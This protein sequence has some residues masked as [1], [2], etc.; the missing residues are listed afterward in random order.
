MP[1][2]CGFIEAATY[3][4]A[5]S[6][7]SLGDTCQQSSLVLHLTQDITFFF[8]HNRRVRRLLVCLYDLP[9]R[10][11]YCNSHILLYYF[12][13]N[14]FGKGGFVLHAY[15]IPRA[16]GPIV[17]EMLGGHSRYEGCFSMEVPP[18]PFTPWL[19][20]KEKKERPLQYRSL[21]LFSIFRQY[22]CD[23]HSQTPWTP[24]L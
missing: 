8:Y 19:A 7:L 3:M 13:V 24:P 16:P 17:Q 10:H 21:H 14:H 9:L 5:T 23:C 1:D 6:W 15:H 18:R 11:E 20:E 4:L 2:P 22:Y 12:S